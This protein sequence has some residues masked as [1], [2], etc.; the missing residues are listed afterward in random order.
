[1]EIS[2]PVFMANT[3]GHVSKN[4]GHFRA[5]QIHMLHILRAQFELA[6]VFR[7]EQI[8]YI[9]PEMVILAIFT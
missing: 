9:E 2:I 7:V 3:F 4:T 8:A 1:M 5:Q 6:M